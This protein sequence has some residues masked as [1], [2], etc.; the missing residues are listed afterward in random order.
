VLRLRPRIVGALSR[1]VLTLCFLSVGALQLCA[2][3]HRAPRY[4]SQIGTTE[5]R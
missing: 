4:R 5:A 3:G 2:S 1:S